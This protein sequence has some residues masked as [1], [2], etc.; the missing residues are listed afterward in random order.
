[1]TTDEQKFFQK[2]KDAAF[3]K[4]E[5]L[6]GYLKPY[7]MKVGV[8]ADHVVFV[9]GY[10][11]PGVYD[12]GEPG[13]PEI[14]LEVSESLADHRVLR[15]HF[16]EQKRAFA[17]A[18]KSRLSERG[19]TGWT[20]H[21]GTAEESLPAVLAAAGDD[22]MLLFLDPYGLAV[23][24]K[25][26][27][28]QVMRRTAITEVVVNFSLAALKR[29]SG[30]LDKDY[31]S[32]TRPGPV[33][34]FGN[35]APPEMTPDRAKVATKKRDA[36]IASLDAFL[37]DPGWHDIKRLGRSSWR[38]EVRQAWVER[39]C[40][41]ARGHWRHWTVPIPEKVDGDPVYDLILF[42]RHAHGVWLF[43]DSASRAYFEHHQRAWSADEHDVPSSLF[44]EPPLD[45][46]LASVADRCVE[47]VA[48]RITS[49]TIR[50]ESFRVSEGMDRLIGNEMRGKVG[51]KHVRAAIKRLHGE[52][53]L[54][55]PTPVGVKRLEDYVITPGPAAAGR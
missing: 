13:S 30:F 9:D 42:T 40:R 45:E 1:M 15:G 21:H 8:N 37:G 43:N 38:Q 4:H 2:R 36:I 18:L 55:G 52:R 5:I 6:S 39:L 31:L 33:D 44:G 25:Q 20:V 7:A 54:G 41:E 47:H 34:L 24:F 19:A 29:L 51:A 32:R 27:V 53:V 26:L 35:R 11:G 28:D 16:I 23:P 10:A 49:A 48:D 3:V 50:G 12:A 14:A 17:E 46:V 22:P